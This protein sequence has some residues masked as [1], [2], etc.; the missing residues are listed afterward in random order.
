MGDKSEQDRRS[1]ISCY[2]SRGPGPAVVLLPPTVGAINH[3]KTR[4]QAPA[5]SLGLKLKSGFGDSKTPG[6]N[7]LIQDG[8]TARGQYRA[9]AYSLRP[10]TK[11][12]DGRNDGPGPA[13]YLP[14]VNVN[15][16]RPPAYSLSARTK[17][18]QSGLFSPG[19]IYMLPSAIGPKIP[20]KPAA[21]ECS[22]KGRGK[23]RKSMSGNAGFY[24]IGRPDIVKNR[25]GWASIKGRYNERNKGYD[26]GP[27]SYNIAG[28]ICRVRNCPPAYSMGIRHTECS[29]NLLTALDK[30]DGCNDPC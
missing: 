10:R 3:D 30:G 7:Y 15:R 25:A 13:A 26:A 8:L 4:T 20:D 1:K 17:L 12:F 16:N 29:G 5:Y 24:D 23:D 11:I 18:F 6:P 19:P 2:A 22:L 21:A 9:P 28:S 27:A 14:E